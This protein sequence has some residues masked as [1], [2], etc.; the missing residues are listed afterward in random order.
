ME[1]RE[2]G[3]SNETDKC[4]SL[5]WPVIRWLRAYVPLGYKR[6]RG[7]VIKQPRDQPDILKLGD[8]S[9]CGETGGDIAGDPGGDAG[10]AGGDVDAV[11]DVGGVDFCPLSLPPKSFANGDLERGDFFFF[12]SSV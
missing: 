9:S 11:G 4:L 10:D 2:T 6:Q 1:K 7:E 8:S 3:Q 12:P 5:G